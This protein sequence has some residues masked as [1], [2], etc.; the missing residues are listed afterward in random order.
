MVHPLVKRFYFALPYLLLYHYYPQRGKTTTIKKKAQR[1]IK[2][3]KSS[4]VTLP[5]LPWQKQERNCQ[6]RFILLLL[7]LSCAPYYDNR[8]FCNGL[9]FEALFY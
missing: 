3:Q 7:G 9:T 4:T 5:R 8:K 2:S 6:M 1:R